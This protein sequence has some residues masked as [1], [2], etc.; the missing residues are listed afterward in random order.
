VFI[1]IRE[2]RET[3]KKFVDSLTEL[4]SSSKDML[5]ESI[6][7]YDG[8]EILVVRCHP[9]C[10]SCFVP[11]ILMGISDEMFICVSGHMDGDLALLHHSIN[12]YRRRLERGPI[13][14]GGIIAQGYLNCSLVANMLNMASSERAADEAKDSV[15]G[16]T[17]KLY[18]NDDSEILHV[19]TNNSKIKKMVDAGKFFKNSCEQQPEDEIVK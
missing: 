4:I 16:L 10:E 1:G 12:S 14:S 5:W 8:F 2:S 17:V 15:K 7:Q 6:G 18:V 9:S 3:G 13:P 19:E 11:D